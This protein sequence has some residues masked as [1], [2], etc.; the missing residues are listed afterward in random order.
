MMI[1]NVTT[2][3]G[4]TQLIPYLKNIENI[5][6]DVEHWYINKVI[7]RV[8]LEKDI[9][10]VIYSPENEVAGF[11]IAKNNKE[12]KKLCC[13][14]IMPDYQGR[15]Y[16]IKLIKKIQKELNEEKLHCSV[17]EDLLHVYSKIFINHFK[18][19]IDE[20]QESKY[21]KGKLEYFFNGKSKKESEL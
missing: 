17:S 13:L 16:A 9:V 11:A 10:L 6:P 18:W 19:T 1:K 14:I 15:G 20:V 4:L 8:M 5:Y 21:K 2:L 12:E 3:I 7:P